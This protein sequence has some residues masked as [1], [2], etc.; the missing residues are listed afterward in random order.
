M[1]LTIANVSTRIQPA[2]FQA[3]VA[4]IGRQVNE[5]FQ[6][7]WGIGATLRGVAAPLIVNKKDVSIQGAHDAI[8]YL[9]DS[10]QDPTVGVEGAL[11]YHSRNFAGIPYG[12]VYLDICAEYGEIWTT[13]LSHETLELL[14]DPTAVITVTG[15]A[16]EGAPGNVYYDLEVCD[17][18]QGDSYEIDNVAVS[19]FVGKSYFD[20]PG[21]GGKTNYLG[22]ELSAF[23]VRPK[24]YFQ[25]EQSN[26]VHQVQGEL[27]TARRLAAKDRMKEGR[28]NTRREISVTST[29]ATNMTTTTQNLQQ[30]L[31]ANPDLRRK[32]SRAATLAAYSVLTDAGIEITDDDVA[33]ARAASKAPVQAD[34]VRDV[35]D[36]V[37]TVLTVASFF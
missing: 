25:Y 11:G 27:V 8:L 9:G 29:G 14:A 12:F 30:V 36:G 7:E 23:G 20:L 35:I 2:A 5:H 26:Q 21:G 6:P 32:A 16:P 31:A 3:A 18:T 1:N 10:S 13:T 34:A 33:Q 24:G 19:N 15:P 22:L 4:A 17:P 37:N 28:R